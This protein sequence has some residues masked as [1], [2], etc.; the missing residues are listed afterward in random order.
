MSMVRC[1]ERMGRATP[2]S[3]TCTRLAF[4]WPTLDCVDLFSVAV[5]FV[6]MMES[7]TSLRAMPE[8]TV[9]ALT[10]WENVLLRSK[11]LLMIITP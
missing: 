7:H 10:T 11:P 5:S 2:L 8:R 4:H 3:A 6:E 9:F 1:V